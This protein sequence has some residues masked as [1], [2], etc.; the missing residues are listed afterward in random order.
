MQRK[1]EMGGGAEE[2]MTE[3]KICGVSKRNIWK[4]LAYFL[5]KFPRGNGITI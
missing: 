3:G 2:I 1:C 4:V 5:S